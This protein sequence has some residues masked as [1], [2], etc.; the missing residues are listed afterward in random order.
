MSGEAAAWGAMGIILVFFAESLLT[1]ALSYD[2]IMAAKLIGPPSAMRPA[3][4][5]LQKTLKNKHFRK[6]KKKN[7]CLEYDRLR[8]I[9]MRLTQFL[10]TQRISVSERIYFR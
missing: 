1:V 8:H 4:D 3:F 2:S 10:A 5:F 7:S 9:L 6:I